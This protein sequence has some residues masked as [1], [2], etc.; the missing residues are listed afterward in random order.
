MVV[1]AE[2]ALAAM[3]ERAE[4]AERAGADREHAL[5][6]ARASD[7]TAEVTHLETERDKLKQKLEAAHRTCKQANEECERVRRRNEQLERE[8]ES[9]REILQSRS[10]A[11]THVDAVIDDLA[12]MERL[13]NRSAAAGL[14]EATDALE[15]GAEMARQK[16][17]GGPQGGARRRISAADG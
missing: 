4:I 14:D 1:V 10:G 17:H 3:L 7:R 13:V 8:L 5:A 12:A 2:A 11:T 16:Q 9:L 6:A 15:L